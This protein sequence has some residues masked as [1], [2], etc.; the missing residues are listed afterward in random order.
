MQIETIETT[1]GQTTWSEQTNQAAPAALQGAP[2][3]TGEEVTAPGGASAQTEG[4]GSIGGTVHA[5]EQGQGAQGQSQGA[6]Q[7]QQGQ[8][9]QQ[10]QG[11]QGQSQGQQGEE[12][13]SG[14]QGEGQGAQGQQEGQ[15][16]EQGTEGQGTEGQEDQGQGEEQGQGQGQEGQGA[17]EQAMKGMSEDQKMDFLS[18]LADSEQAR[19]WTESEIRDIAAAVFQEDWA[20]V[21]Q[22]I[23]MVGSRIQAATTARCKAAYEGMQSRIESEFAELKAI[24][25]KTLVLKPAAGQPGEPRAMGLCHETTAKIISLLT[26]NIPVF[27]TG[28]AGSGKTTV[29]EK[30]AEALGLSFHPVSV[31][32]ETMKSDLLGFIDG[33]GHY[34]TTPVREAFEKGGLL[35]L[36]EMDA[37]NGASMTILNSLIANGYCSFP[38]RFVKRHPNFRIIAAAN[39][40]G[41]G[42]DRLYVGRNQLDAATLDRFFVQAFDYDENLER[43]LAGNDQWVDRVQR[44]RKA[45]S[46]LKL[47]VVVSP[48]ASIM[49]ARLLAYG[50]PQKQVEEGL[51]FKYDESFRRKIK[52]VGVEA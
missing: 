8:G 4:I 21:D 31:G 43:R 35:L 14:E 52:D 30:V 10:G 24:R 22:L 41:R 27:L 47:R 7:G 25:P 36:D 49:G 40:F 13:G 26:N 11:G 16:Q 51:I 3:L 2:D 33:N 32:P 19:E 12:Q 5:E 1:E 9:S 46:E 20:N 45:A 48:R 38:D 39:T 29:A 44:I 28:P 17:Q 50:I 23:E 6:G 34:H 37:G 42:A 15:G 18:R